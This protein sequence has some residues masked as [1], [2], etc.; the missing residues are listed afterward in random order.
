MQSN[1]IEVSS[2][3]LT[4]Q[5]NVPKYM[6]IQ[7]NNMHADN[8]CEDEDCIDE[9]KD[10]VLTMIHGTVATDIMKDVSINVKAN[11]ISISCNC[12]DEDRND[13]MNK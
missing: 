2:I 6:T 4:S 8:D 10:D 11:E 5:E 7:L 12:N 9:T 1:S 13:T 3:A